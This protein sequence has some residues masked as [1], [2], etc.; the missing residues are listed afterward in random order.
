M[1]ERTYAPRSGGRT[2]EHGDTAVPAS[3]ARTARRNPAR[4]MAGR[5]HADRVPRG[6]RARRR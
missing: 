1:S 6:P 5:Q 2:A 3:G 4:G